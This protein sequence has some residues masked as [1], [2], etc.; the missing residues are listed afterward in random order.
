MYCLKRIIDPISLAM[1]LDDATYHEVMAAQRNLIRALE[2]EHKFDLL[3]RNYEELEAEFLKIS[4]RTAIYSDRD[5]DV[6]IDMLQ[7]MNRRLV[8]LLTAARLY[9]DQLAHDLGKIFGKDSSSFQSFDSTRKSNHAGRLGY[10][11]C[12]MLRNY[13]QHRG[14]PCQR[15]HRQSSRVEESERTRAHVRIFVKMV[16]DRKVLKNDPKVPSRV[17]ADLEKLEEDPDLKPLVRE[18]LGGLGEV[19]AHTRTLLAE[20]IASWEQTVDH[21][22]SRYRHD[23]DNDDLAGLAL[24]ELNGEQTIATL[25]LV[26][27]MNVRGRRIALAKKNR[28]TSHFGNVVATNY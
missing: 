5:W 4:L 7:D 1:K 6:G 21:A 13:I 15:I 8:N 11:V 17:R 25:D 23:K 9:L 20:P 28:S 12:E 27:D 16:L 3:V 14:M 10:R 19:H 2:I 18:Y 26:G 22:I 24:V